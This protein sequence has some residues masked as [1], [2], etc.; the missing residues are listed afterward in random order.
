MTYI[1]QWQQGELTYSRPMKAILVCTFYNHAMP[2]RDLNP[3]T[4]DSMTTFI[5]L[6]S[7]MRGL[8]QPLDCPARAGN[9]LNGGEI[10]KSLTIVF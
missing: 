1:E 8:K 6:R 2:K 10:S 7:L 4:T 5:I 9:K 3:Q